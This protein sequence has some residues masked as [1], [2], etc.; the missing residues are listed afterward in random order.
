M[1]KRTF[2]WVLPVA[3]VGAAGW[4]VWARRDQLASLRDADPLLLALAIPL[5]LVAQL[6]HGL[7]FRTSA[8]VLGVRVGFHDWFGLTVAN[9]MLN[10]LSP[11]RAGVGARAV[12]MKRRHG[13]SYARFAALLMG[14]NILALGTAALVGLAASAVGW[15]L[16]GGGWADC[17]VIFLGLTIVMGAG[18][19]VLA[20]STRVTG[21]APTQWL[22]D[23]LASAADGLRLFPK[24]GRLVALHVVLCVLHQAT[25]ASVLWVC[26]RGT[27]LDADP[28]RVLVLQCGGAFS[29]AL[30]VSPGGIGV[31][32]WIMRLL[33]SLLDMSPPRV[34]LAALTRRALGMVTTLL[35]GL[36]ASH[37]LLG[38]I[39]AGT[40]APG[41]HMPDDGDACCA[42]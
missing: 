39:M 7:Q 6:L 34:M 37:R 13:L 20:A 11:L 23:R 8:A 25:A 26:C 2:K 3:L 41:P 5:G 33:G 36:P 24:Q 1:L 38:D 15:R 32:E 12:Y 18:T 21:L 31:R 27:G 17:V 35:V 14:T 4:Y 30:P 22:R 29:M 9:T 40:A 42:S 28:L 19:A 10:Q 16:Y